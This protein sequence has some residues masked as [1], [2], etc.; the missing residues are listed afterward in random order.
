M[1]SFWNN[2]Y[3]KPL[4]QIPWQNTQ[5]DWFRELVDNSKVSGTKALDLG[6]GTGMKS[7]YLAKHRFNEV[8][9]VDIS[10]QA[11]EYAKKNAEEENVGDVCKFYIGDISANNWNFVE[12]DKR[13]DLIVDWAAIHCLSRK[14]LIQYAKNVEMHCKNGGVY[15]VRFFSTTSDTQFFT[16]DTAED[17]MDILLLDEKDIQELFTNFK[18][19]ERNISYPSAQK[20]EQGYYFTELM[21]ERI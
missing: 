17:L 21:M 12:E 9:G 18:I 15:L 11:I 16:E 6:C 8:V 14:Y 4:D 7:I 19:I 20:K 2:Y 3:K 13:F 5:S 10:A 1:N